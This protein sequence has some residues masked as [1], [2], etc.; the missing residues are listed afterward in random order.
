MTTHNDASTLPE[1]WAEALRKRKFDMDQLASLVDGIYDGSP[2]G[3]VFPHRSDVF[4]AFFLTKLED[5]RVVI[6]GQDPYPQ[7]GQAHGLAFSVPEQVP[8]PRSLSAVFRNLESD[9]GA[10]VPFTRPSHG[11]L[12]SWAKQGVLLLNTALT[13]EQRNAGS[14]SRPWKS[15]IDLVL[16][17]VNEERDHVAFLLWGK[18]AINRASAVGISEPPHIT[19]KSAHPTA[20]GRTKQ[21]PFKD[22]HPFSDANAF[23]GINDA[24]PVNWGLGATPTNKRAQT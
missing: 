5:V 4:R 13:V 22:C 19:F 24:R 12:S 23:L 2:P 9:H 15:F 18:H 16:Q 20:R 6:L 11:D 21:K 8:I 17:V 3:S 7:P 10:N 1:D 14:H